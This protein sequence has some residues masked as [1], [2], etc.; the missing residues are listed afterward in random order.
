MSTILFQFLWRPYIQNEVSRL[1]VVDIPLMSRV[2]VPIICF[3]TIEIHQA[4][5]VMCQ[6]GLRQKIPPNQVN[7]DQVHRDN[8]R[9]RNDKD[10]V[11]QHH[12][13]IAIW[14]DRQNWIIQGTP[15][16]ENGHLNDQ[17]PYMQWYIN[18]T[19]CYISPSTKSS[20]DEVIFTTMLCICLSYILIHGNNPTIYFTV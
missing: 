9:G 16:S 3:A 13:W 2:T 7:L 17:T 14:N 19:I 6:F 18:H 12:Q 11:A 15:F 1:I 4:D 20:G 5:R 8:L 10:W